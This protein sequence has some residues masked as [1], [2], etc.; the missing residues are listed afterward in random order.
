MGAS[1]GHQQHPGHKVLE[2]QAAGRMTVELG[3]ML[4]ADSRD[5]L[6][7]EESDHPVRFYFPRKDVRMDCLKASA[8]RTKCPFKGTAS[9]FDVLGPKG[10]LED[11][12][13][14]Y[15]Q[16]YE[17]H[18]GLRERL[19]FDEAASPSLKIRKVP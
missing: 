5:V 8:T 19:A 16:P 12:V 17:E 11:G 4:I 10:K 15:E 18:R 14:S 9:Y 3:G 13:W 7:V 2:S 6:R 1:P